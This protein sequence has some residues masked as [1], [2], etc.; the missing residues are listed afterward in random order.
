MSNDLIAP[1]TGHSMADIVRIGEAIAKSGLFGIRSADQAI[2]LCLIAQAEGRHPALAARDY[3]IIQGR[4]SK[5]A[6]AMLRDFLS[7][8]GRVEWHKLADDI[9]D[10]TFSH[11]AG[12]SARI[13]W[14]MARVRKAGL[15]G[16]DMYSKFPRSMLRSRVVS[17]G[18]RT[19]WPSATGGMY[20][21]DEVAAFGEMIDVTPEPGPIVTSD[22]E[23]T[24][25]KPFAIVDV[26][27]VEHSF[28]TAE[29]ATNA[30]LGVLAD[31]ANLGLARLNGTIESNHALVSYI[32]ALGHSAEFDRIVATVKELRAGLKQKE[33]EQSKQ[34]P[35]SLLSELDG[36]G[37]APPELDDRPER[38]ITPT[39]RNGKPEWAAWMTA[40]TRALSTAVTTPALAG[41]LG[42]NEAHITAYKAAMGP[43]IAGAFD[44]LVAKQWQKVQD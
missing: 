12:G 38:E 11:P 6:E 36:E 31:A 19:V 30:L 40:F 43:R 35:R 1:A 9:A 44:T 25:D 34:E 13:V 22:A 4:P 33:A 10:A 7:A 29:G 5:K 32:D 23:S 39:M 14:D 24:G 20:V 26:E 18:V 3:D 21:P 17:E 8:G 41:L 16:K 2:A 42:D 28:D 37:V 27:G 15:A